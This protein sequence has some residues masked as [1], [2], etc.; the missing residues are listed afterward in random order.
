LLF[1]AGRYYFH[2]SGRPSGQN[3][4]DIPAEILAVSEDGRDSR[5]LASFPIRGFVT[6]DRYGGW[7][8][9][10]YNDLIVVP[11]GNRQFIL[12]HT[13][14]YLIKMCDRESGAAF[15]EFRRAYKRVPMP[16][17]MAGGV[18]GMGGASS[19]MPKYLNDIMNLHTSEGRILV[20]TS[21]VDE[22]KGLLIDVFDS[23][24][25][26]ADCFYLKL[27]EK[28]MDAGLAFTRLVFAGGA[29]YIV[30]QTDE[31]LVAIKKCRLSGG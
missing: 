11:F 9:L 17:R 12:T 2:S 28:K 21:T 18:S 5:L 23:D 26:Y 13:P 4:T 27:S 19:E 24:G 3:W 16:A 8:I 30:E 20:Q 29:V 10:Q 31:G 1:D 15:R 6:V 25:R 22:A 7:G 14:E